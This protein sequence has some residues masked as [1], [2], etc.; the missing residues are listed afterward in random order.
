MKRAKLKSSHCPGAAILCLLLFGCLAVAQTSEKMRAKYGHPSQEDY[1]LNHQ[2]SLAVKFA[3]DGQACEI[4]LVGADQSVSAKQIVDDLI[5]IS[6]RG[7]LIS[8]DGEVGNCLDHWTL[9]YVKVD[10]YF[11]DDACGL[12]RRSDQERP[13]RAHIVWKN[14]S[15]KV[16]PAKPQPKKAMNRTRN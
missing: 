6:Q 15:C 10:V 8:S 12:Y 3:E 9:S 14:R 2:V 7:R 1:Q 4:L 5:P 11:D 16:G 13:V